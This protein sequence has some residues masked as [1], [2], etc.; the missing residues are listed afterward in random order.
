MWNAHRELSKTVPGISLRPLVTF[1]WFY[2]VWW[3]SWK[4]MILVIFGKNNRT[5]WNHKNWSRRLRDIPGTV[6]ESSE[7][8]LSISKKILEIWHF[9]EPERYCYIL[10]PKTRHGHLLTVL[11]P[12]RHQNSKFCWCNQYFRKVWIVGFPKP[13]SEFPLDVWLWFYVFLK[14]GKNG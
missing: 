9:L 1:L 5:S 4:I 10:S 12:K 3:K 13:V 2:E 7:R 11:V 8:I 6:L 14:F